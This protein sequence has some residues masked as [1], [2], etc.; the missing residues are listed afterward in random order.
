MLSIKTLKI[1]EKVGFALVIIGFL[2]DAKI[3]DQTDSPMSFFGEGNNYIFLIGLV[4]WALSFGIRKIEERK[5]NG[6]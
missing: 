4:V 6:E 3:S 1:L 5:A 2:I